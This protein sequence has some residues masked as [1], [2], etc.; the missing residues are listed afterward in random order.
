MIICNDSMAYFV[1]LA[2]GR[3]II[4]KPFLSLSPNKTWEGMLDLA[5]LFCGVTVFLEQQMHS[6]Y[7][8]YALT[9][10]CPEFCKSVLF[11]A[12]TPTI[13]PQASSEELF[14]HAS[15]PFSCL[16]CSTRPGSSALCPSH[17]YGSSGWLQNNSKLSRFHTFFFSPSAPLIFLQSYI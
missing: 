8:K 14:S 13:E 11:H 7:S 9:C 15:W 6:E 3:K 17:G 5:N 2:C 10:A 16:P 1:G 4:K 12:T